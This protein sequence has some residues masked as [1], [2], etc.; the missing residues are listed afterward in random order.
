MLAGA[1][2]TALVFPFL[3]HIP[4]DWTETAVY[5]YLL[6][7]GWLYF[8]CYTMWSMS[9]YSME[10]ELTPNYDERTRIA[11]WISV[12]GKLGA[13]LGGWSI[14]ILS[15]QLFANPETGEPDLVRGM[16]ACS[17][18][19]A[20]IIFIIG[21]LPAF[22]VKERYYEADASKQKKT[23]LLQ[24]IRESASCG[25]LWCLV[26]CSSFLLLGNASVAS[27]NQYINIYYISNGDLEQAGT[28]M[29]WRTNV[30]VAAGLLLIPLW[31]KLSEQF[32]KR[33]MVLLA[34]G[35]AIFGHLLNLF[36]MRPDHPYWQVIPAVFESGA[37]SAF[38]MLLPSMKA[39]V[40]DYDERLTHR[41]RE[42]ALNAFYAWFIKASLTIALGLSGYI[43]DVAGYD[44]TLTTQP[45]PVLDKMFVI[46]LTLP[47]VFWVAGLAFIWA[48]PLT[49]EKMDD[50][51]AELEATRGKV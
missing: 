45:A 17:W 5:V 41:R 29:G 37:I 48:Y 36:M 44:A 32:G 31:T 47:T 1:T 22:F 9:Y 14:A 27:L 25:P 21:A 26:G 24:S 28:V 20:I 30:M 18:Y 49:R 34:M 8:T 39:D 12:F 46:Y 50:I 4:A 7:L 2:F 42:G 6:L 10:M 43:L 40:A 13:L 35:C 33:S 16:Q 23:P 51:R 19:L 38:W 3:W 11:A 15:S